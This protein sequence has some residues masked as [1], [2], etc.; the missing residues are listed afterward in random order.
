MHKRQIDS[1]RRNAQ[2]YG[3]SNLKIGFNV[4]VKWS[5][6]FRCLD[7]ALYGYG[8]SL[9][10]FR[11]VSPYLILPVLNKLLHDVWAIGLKIESSN[12]KKNNMI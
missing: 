10:D 12:D 8:K 6:T 11:Y 5:P 1:D 4:I 3:V 2:A 7:S 9:M